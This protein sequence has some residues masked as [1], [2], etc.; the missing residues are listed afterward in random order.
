MTQPPL[1]DLARGKGGVRS[2]TSRGRPGG[3]FPRSS[4]RV[5]SG[6]ASW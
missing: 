3:G 2:M 5:F 4:M 6:D 1:V